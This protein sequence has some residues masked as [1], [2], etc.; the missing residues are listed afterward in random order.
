VADRR[1]SLHCRRVVA[2]LGLLLLVMAVGSLAVGAAPIGLGE[3]LAGF[4]DNHAVAGLILRDIRLPRTLLAL[5]VGATLGLSGAA[6][7]GLLRNPL[8]DPAV[9]GAP[10]GAAFGA[11]IML[12]FGLADAL[13]PLLPLVAVAFALLTFGAVVSIAG[14]EASVTIVVLAGLAMAS[15]AG[16][17]TSVVISLS[18]N[19]FAVTEIIFWLLGSF[20]DRSLRHVLLALPFLLACWL[21]IL[22][23]GEGLRVLVLG[24]EAAT[25]LGIAVPRLRFLMIAAVALGLG[26]AVSV[27]GAIGFVGLVAPHLARGLVGSDPRRVLIPAALIGAALTLG[28]DIAVRLIPSTSELRVG[29]VTAL[30]GV[31]FFLWIVARRR[32]ALAAGAA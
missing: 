9:F 4:F 5:V 21:I 6:L 26:G 11:V 3:G 18:P 28:A 31:P 2:A 27:S 25:S 30:M 19:P 17:A 22:A 29:A 8:A 20:E 13:S 12:Y 24:E 7:Q 15:L 14:R 16:A 32:A 1:Q 10:Q 23:R